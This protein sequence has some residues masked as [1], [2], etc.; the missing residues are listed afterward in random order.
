MKRRILRLTAL[1]LA[2]LLTAVPLSSCHPAS[3]GAGETELPEILVGSDE[4]EPFFYAGEGDS[5]TG[6]DVELATEAFRRM[7]YRAKFVKIKWTRKDVLLKDGTIDCLWGCFSMTGRE[8]D[9]TWTGPYL[10]SR[11][12]VVVPAESDIYTLADLADKRVAVQATSKPDEIFSAGTD[13]RIPQIKNLYCFPSNDNVFA[14]L[15]KGYVDAIA[16][17]DAALETRMK[18]Y[19]AGSYRILEENLLKVQLGVAFA[20]G[21]H[22]ELA[23]KLTATFAELTA[24]GFV[25]TLLEK[26]GMNAAESLTGIKGY[27]KE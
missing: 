2:L 13:P 8:N 20:K 1:I 22:E 24:D 4:Y 6:F 3:D 27:G 17:H 5:F 15:R 7:G 11:Q 10:N 21:T 14:A 23:Q 16:G 12:V 9:Y 25:Q 19:P 18:E 26:Y